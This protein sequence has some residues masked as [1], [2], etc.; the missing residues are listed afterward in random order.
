ML[1]A[2]RSIVTHATPA[3]IWE[4]WSDVETWHTW[5][6]GLDSVSIEGE[7]VTGANGWLKPANG[8]KVKLELVNVRTNEFF[9]D[10]TKLPLGWLDFF[11]TLE[12][13]EEQTKITQQIQMHG[14]LTFIFSRLIGSGLKKRLPSVMNRLV[15]IAE[16]P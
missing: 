8:P 14:P 16:K 10:R 2:K 9:H 4:F 6:D 12:R 11:H 13:V 7:F 15:H 1:I 3:R 5:D